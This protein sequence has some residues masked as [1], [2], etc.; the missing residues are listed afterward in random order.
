M[1][2]GITGHWIGPCK[3]VFREV[4]LNARV[5]VERLQFRPNVRGVRVE[6]IMEPLVIQHIVAGSEVTPS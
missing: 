2:P 4:K 3:V 1:Y 5:P 6:P